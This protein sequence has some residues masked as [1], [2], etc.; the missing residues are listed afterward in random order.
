M[1]RL[2]K[3]PNPERYDLNLSVDPARDRFEG[4]LEIALRTG[5]GARRVELH[6]ADLD[7][8]EASARDAGGP[9]R[10]AR[11]A[12]RPKQERI[13]LELA[14]PLRGPGASL[15][16]RYS[17]PIRS[18]LRGLYLARSGK[19]RYAVTQLEAADARRFFPCFDEP[20]RKARFRLSV[21]TPRQ[22]EI[23][24]NSPA[25]K[26]E[27]HGRTKTTHFAETP[28][29]STYLIALIVGELEGSRARRSGR[30]PIRV[31]HVPGKGGLTDFALEAAAA[32]LARLEKYFGLPYPYAKLD[33]IAV[34]DF[35]FGAMENA[36]AVT[37]RETLLLVDPRTVT[38][39]EKKRVAEVIAHELA[40]MWYGDL[41]TMAWWDDLWL[42]EAFATWMAFTIVDQW[43]PD[44]KMWLDF[45]H[46]RAAAFGLDAMRNTHPIYAAVETPAEATENFDAITYEKGASVVRMIERWLGAAT[47]RKGVRSYIR[48]HRES[49]AR[50]ADLWGALEEASGRPVAPVVRAWIERPGFPL[51]SVRRARRGGR[52]RLELRQERFFA[53]PKESDEARRASWPIPALIRVRG[54]RGRDRLERLLLSR[55]R[56]SADLGGAGSVRWVYANAEEGGFYRPLHDAALLHGISSELAR[57]DPAERLGLLGHQWAGLRANRAPLDDFLHLVE[58]LETEPEPEVLDGLIGPLGLLEDLVAPAAERGEPTRFRAW[59]ASVFR[60]AFD[61]HGWVAG[62]RE[63]RDRGLR[64]AALLRLVGGVAE[65]PEV[66]PDAERHLANYL[67]RRTALDANLAGPVVELG[68]RLGDKRRYEQYLTAMRRA[69]TPQERTR[70]ELALGSFR[71]PALVGRTLE[72]SLG[73]DIPTQDV[74][75]LLV[76]LLQNR[77]ARE[78]TWRFLQERWAD[79]SPRV[80]AGLASRLINALPALQTRAYRKQVADFFKAHPQPTATRALKQALERFDLDA[81]LRRRTAPALRRWLASSGRGAPSPA[82]PAGRVVRAA[83]RRRSRPRRAARKAT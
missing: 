53:S 28:P 48:R 65:D 19:R 37:F 76:R 60:P 68:A 15:R 7:I 29:L 43:K 78:A 10:V 35:E 34:P 31:W 62:R 82:A 81:E 13:A 58:A 5:S 40:H 26:T 4:E 50:A 21:T 61:D 57:L 22:N 2:P 46:H 47:F 36:G 20:D 18:D 59:V 11:I 30:T 17:G 32:S 63:P 27:V 23:I 49:N 14:R 52:E 39:A 67:R 69:A 66:L 1:S 12:L 3:S 75:P 64:R 72:L 70:F 54:T 16:L 80:P 33:L 71:D 55:S 8:E 73:D 42:N 77:A 74:V 45:Q 24:S 9:V 38:H 51:V 56:Q 25:E 83:G 41:V 79:V 6:A 44:W